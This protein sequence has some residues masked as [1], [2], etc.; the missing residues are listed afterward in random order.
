MWHYNPNSWSVKV[1]P[2]TPPPPTKK[3]SGEIKFSIHDE[4]IEPTASQSAHSELN[5]NDSCLYMFR[6]IWQTT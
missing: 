2:P 6:K 3:D 1:S 5:R 4:G